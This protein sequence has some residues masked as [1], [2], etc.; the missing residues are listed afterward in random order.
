MEQADAAFGVLD[1]GRDD[2]VLDIEAM[3]AALEG[4]FHQVAAMDQRRRA[5]GPV[6]VLADLATKQVAGEQVVR[7]RDAEVARGLILHHDACGADGAR[8]G[9]RPAG[10][11][12][13]Q[14]D[15]AIPTA[16]HRMRERFRHRGIG[17][18]V[19][20]ATIRF[21]GEGGGEAVGQPRRRHKPREA[22][23]QTVPHRIHATA[24]HH[25]RSSR[26]AWGR[27]RVGG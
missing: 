8:R 22:T 6:Q 10:Q 17:R 26:A 7:R 2:G 5:V 12:Q 14:V 1:A 21:L 19:E 25:P 3:P 4:E 16:Q 18:E 11:R 27:D 23:R 9:A 24:A 15:G 20:D 13:Q